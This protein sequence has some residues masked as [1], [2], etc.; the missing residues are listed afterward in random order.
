MSHPFVARLVA[1]LLAGAAL[2]ATTATS[3]AGRRRAVGLRPSDP[4]ATRRLW[5]VGAVLVLGAAAYELLGRTSGLTVAMAGVSAVVAGRR[6]QRRRRRQEREQLGAALVEAVSSLGAALAAGRLPAD[7]LRDLVEGPAPADATQA[8]L[9]ALLRPAAE[10]ARL[11]GSVP[12]QLRR[13]SLVDGCGDLRRVAAAW[14]LADTAGA[15]LVAA[16]DRVGASL[17][18]QAQH[19]REVAAELAGARASARLVAGL[20][21]VGLLIGAGLGAR[22]VEVLVETTYGQVALGLGVSLELL[23]LA[24]TDRIAEAALRW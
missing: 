2:W 5:P 15:P 14:H 3:A 1:G 7:A 6:I 24:W 10:A 9:A 20:P 21:V 16:L 18:R 8:R 17:R 11:G 4:R 12:E 13:V 19:R 23:G 22:P